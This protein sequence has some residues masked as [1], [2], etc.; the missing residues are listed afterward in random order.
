M[1]EGTVLFMQAMN[2]F[3]DNC[4]Y[5]EYDEDNDETID[6]LVPFCFP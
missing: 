4:S 2:G 5:I 1:K 6:D 3:Q